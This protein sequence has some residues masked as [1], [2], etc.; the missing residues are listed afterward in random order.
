MYPNF[1]L[2]LGVMLAGFLSVIIRSV[3]LQGGV[4]PIISDSQRGGRLNF[5]EWVCV[6]FEWLFLRVRR[7][8]LPIQDLQNQHVFVI[9]NFTEWLEKALMRLDVNIL[10]NHN[11]TQHFVIVQYYSSSYETQTAMFM[12]VTFKPDVLSVSLHGAESKVSVKFFVV[13][14]DKGLR[15]ARRN[16]GELTL[17]IRR[18]KLLNL[19]TV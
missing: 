7:D 12:Y 18:N 11:S 3:G 9:I 10:I 5:W 15:N 2:Q 8:E 17:R 16:I 6:T 19:G 13:Q 14:V 4:F 1:P